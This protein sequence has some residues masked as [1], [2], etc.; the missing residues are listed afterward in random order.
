MTEERKEGDYQRQDGVGI[1]R[2]N[3]NEKYER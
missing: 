3:V 2:L 1:I